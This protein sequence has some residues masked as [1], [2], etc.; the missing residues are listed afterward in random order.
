MDGGDRGGVDGV[1]VDV[2]AVLWD[3]EGVMGR[4]MGG[5]DI[6]RL[7]NGRRMEWERRKPWR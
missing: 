5:Y 7:E 6:G 4:V 2:D 1:C 3:C